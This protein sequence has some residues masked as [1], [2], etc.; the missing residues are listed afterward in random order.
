MVLSLFSASFLRVLGTF[1][2]RFLAVRCG[3][4]T[5]RVVCGK[6]PCCV[7]SAWRTGAQ[8]GPCCSYS[9]GHSF[10]KHLRPD[11]TLGPHNSILGSHRLWTSAPGATPHYSLKLS[12]EITL[13]YVQPLPSESP[14]TYNHIQS[15]IQRSFSHLSRYRCT[16]L[17]VPD[18]IHAP[19]LKM[20]KPM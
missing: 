10:I 9:S 6:Q 15:E 12:G 13:E 14:I 20:R 16:P 19:F 5:R 8:S 3:H 4:R 11:C 1:A 2:E 17:K 18:L 7:H